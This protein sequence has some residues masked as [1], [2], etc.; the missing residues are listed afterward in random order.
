VSRFLDLLNQLPKCKGEIP[1]GLLKRLDAA[2]INLINNLDS[3]YDLPEEERRSYSADD[4]LEVQNRPGG[5]G[6]Q[7]KSPL[8]LG[9]L[10]VFKYETDKFWYLRIRF[11]RAPYTMIRFGSEE[12]ILAEEKRLNTLRETEGEEA[13]EDE[14]M[15]LIDVYMDAEMPE[16]EGSALDAL[17]DY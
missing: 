2:A 16:C 13:F 9:D 12:E 4:L 5:R 7:G 14:V 11:G 1:E 10:E 17:L 15:R 6:L 3:Q 8:P